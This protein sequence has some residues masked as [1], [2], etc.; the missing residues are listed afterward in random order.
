[1]CRRVGRFS[2]LGGGC[3]ELSWVKVAGLF[4]AGENCL[5]L[6]HYLNPWLG[7]AVPQRAQ[8]TA[9]S[10]AYSAAQQGAPPFTPPRNGHCHM[11]ASV[12]RS[13]HTCMMMRLPTQGFPSILKPWFWLASVLGRGGGVV[14]SCTSPRVGL[15][16]EGRIFLE[17]MVLSIFYFL[18]CFFEFFIS[19]FRGLANSGPGIKQDRKSKGQERNTFFRALGGL[20]TFQ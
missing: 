3:A 16:Y 9:R 14:S 18:K 17:I 11:L 5:P 4:G 7:A 20:K 6:S 10:D 2:G 1:M 15:F 19:I 8:V 12:R 13:G